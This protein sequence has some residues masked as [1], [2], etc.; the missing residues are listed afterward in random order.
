MTNSIIISIPQG[1]NFS[2]L[3]QQLRASIP[4]YIDGGGGGT[5]AT[6]NFSTDPVSDADIV[7]LTTICVAHDPTQKSAEQIAA[8][9]AAAAAQQQQITIGTELAQVEATLTT[10]G[11]ANMADLP[12]V[13]AAIKTVAASLAQ[14]VHVIGTLYQ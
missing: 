2:L 6:L 8:D 1:V 11:S 9:A 5:S 14:I 3:E 10:L 13:V 12:A 4:A 7:Q